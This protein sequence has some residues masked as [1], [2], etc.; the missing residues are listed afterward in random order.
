MGLFLLPSTNNRC[1][2]LAAAAASCRC[3]VFHTKYSSRHIINHCQNVYTIY[4][5]ENNTE[6]VKK[7]SKQNEEAEGDDENEKEDEECLD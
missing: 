1:F 7:I 4:C 6:E 2:T 5:Y 3:A